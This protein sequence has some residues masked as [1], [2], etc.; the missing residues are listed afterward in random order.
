[1]SDF[2]R[3]EIKAFAV[4]GICSILPLDRESGSEISEYAI[5]NLHT[6]ESV[7][8]Y[9]LGLLGESQDT[10][11]FVEKLQSMVFG[12]D[13]KVGP[14]EEAM[15][16][17]K[18]PSP[19]T[20]LPKKQ[21]LSKPPQKRLQP[22]VRSEREGHPLDLKS[23]KN[24]PSVIAPQKEISKTKPQKD[25]KTTLKDI[26]S[27][28]AELELETD[29][30]DRKCNCN[31]QRHPLFR[32]FPNCLNCGKIICEKEGLQPCSF[33]GKP[34]LSHRE[35]LE[36]LDVLQKEKLQIE[37]KPVVKQREGP[38]KKEK[39]KISINSAGINS[40]KQQ[41][42]F[43]K[44]LDKKRLDEKKDL[45]NAEKLQKERKDQESE[46]EFYQ[47][48]KDKD[49]ALL[50]AQERLEKLLQFQDTGTERTKIIDQA[51]DF[52]MPNQQMSLWSSP[53]ERAL[54]LRKQ[55][56]RLRKQDQAEKE[57]SGRGHKVME[58]VIH[59]GKVVMRETI[60]HDDQDEEDTKDIED[61]ESKVKN[62]ITERDL[63]AR[64]AVWDPA[65][66]AQQWQAPVYVGNGENE[67][68]EPVHSWRV[69]Q[70]DEDEMS[71]LTGMPSL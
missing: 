69:Q 65:K 32:M 50:E 17:E 22:S 20:E 57:R 60:A 33:C 11:E 70:G 63:E 36:I 16:V 43:F 37:G 45:E 39:V 46:L 15:K 49:P 52:D 56:R 34:L 35:R 64:K 19:Q 30:P 54:Q 21:V 6:R 48:F 14:K 51:A 8:E 18:A 26:D 55:Q 66:D 31:A 53:V 23:E 42:A 41:E 7:S 40:F 25:K 12:D 10:F 9:F 13:F 47:S 38:K 27:A 1:M 44:K 61:L 29:T 24:Q 28:L 71:N 4:D 3:A 58:M 68:S 67:I 59:D 62:S 2:S 5:S